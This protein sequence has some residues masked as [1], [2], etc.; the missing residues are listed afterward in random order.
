M[1]PDFNGGLFQYRYD[2]FRLNSRKTSRVRIDCDFL[3]RGD[4]KT[5]AYM[6]AMMLPRFG[7]VVG[8]PR[9][10]LLFAE[11][12]RPYAS[13][14]PPLIVDDV[15][16]TGGSIE[17]ARLKQGFVLGEPIGR[18]IFARGP[19][20][21]WVYPL[22]TCN[23]PLEKVCLSCPENPKHQENSRTPTENF[24]KKSTA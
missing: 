19:C 20:P 15:L 13:Y 12:M 17:R 9:G 3:T 16:T 4:V 23:V 24:G 14:G 21:D 18:V 10:G 1:N 11:A 5:L 7:P 6:A 2:G 22:F 8:V